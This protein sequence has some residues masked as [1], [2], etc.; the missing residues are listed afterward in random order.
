MIQQNRCKVIHHLDKSCG[1]NNLCMVHNDV[2]LSAPHPTPILLCTHSNQLDQ[3]RSIKRSCSPL[4]QILEPPSTGFARILNPNCNFLKTRYYTT[5][6][7]AQSS[8]LNR[9]GN[10][11]HCF[12]PV[13][14]DDEVR[15]ALFR[16]LFHDQ[17]RIDQLPSQLA[18]LNVVI[19]LHLRDSLLDRVD[20]NRQTVELLVPREPT[21][22]FHAP[23]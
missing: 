22:L 6:K 15:S 12:V 10:S 23:R 14:V 11:A 5:H 20:V 8:T 3:S 18:D 1:G 13:K 21:R 16:H 9:I 19:E 4:C 2:F 17:P 7:A